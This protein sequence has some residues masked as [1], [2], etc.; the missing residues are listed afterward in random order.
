MY[1]PTAV[2]VHIISFLYHD[3]IVSNYLYEPSVECHR[4]SYNAEGSHLMDLLGNA[5]VIGDLCQPY[6][7]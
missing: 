4:D 6:R 5:L 2:Y 7:L 1:T 3:S